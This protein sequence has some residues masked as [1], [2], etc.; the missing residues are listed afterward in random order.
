[1]DV[2]KA[3]TLFSRHGKWQPPIK[4]SDCQVKEIFFSQSKNYRLCLDSSNSLAIWCCRLLI[5]CI[6]RSFF[7]SAKGKEH[8]KFLFSEDLWEWVPGWCSKPA[9]PVTSNNNVRVAL[10]FLMF[11]TGWQSNFA[12]AYGP[13]TGHITSSQVGSITNSTA[14][15]YLIIHLM[16]I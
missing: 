6:C 7:L 10:A 2:F 1:M 11:V 3:L 8:A 13:C 16:L 9:L 14:P 4:Y 15:V 5:F 12:P